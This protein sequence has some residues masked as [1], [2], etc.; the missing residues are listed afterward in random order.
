MNLRTS[1]TPLCVK[2][3][4]GSQSKIKLKHKCPL[5]RLHTMG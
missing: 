4:S 2:R 1:T 3:G 5:T